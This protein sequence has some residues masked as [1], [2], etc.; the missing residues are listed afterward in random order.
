M[1]RHVVALIIFI[2][3]TAAFSARATEPALQLASADSGAYQVNL[4]GGQDFDM[5]QSGEILCPA[6]FLLCDD[7]KV[8]VP[9]ETSSGLGF[10]GVAP[11][12][13]ICS[14]ISANGLRR[15]F[16]ITVR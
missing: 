14:A 11:G 2:S 7:P 16:S 10:R 9:A 12:T 1:G 4:L 8:A 3:I 13:T 5:C 15:V 6:R